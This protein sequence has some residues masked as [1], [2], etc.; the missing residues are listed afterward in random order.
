MEGRIRKLRCIR[1]LHQG[2]HHGGG[3]LLWTAESAACQ[4]SED[5]GASSVGR[6][7]VHREG[8]VVLPVLG[9][10]DFEKRVGNGG[11]QRKRGRNPNEA[12]SLPL[13]ISQ[14]TG[15]PPIKCLVNVV[16]ATEADGTSTEI[17]HSPTDEKDSAFQPHKDVVAKTTFS[18]FAFVE[19]IRGAFLLIT[20]VN[21][22]CLLITCGAGRGT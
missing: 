5:A 22:L 10:A 9:T 16:G 12:L 8:L 13:S 17:H 3:H 21:F 20:F 11:R 14:I 4:G 2:H 15:M 18:P 6:V 7:T 1:E 19:I